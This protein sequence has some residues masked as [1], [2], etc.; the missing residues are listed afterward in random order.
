MRYYWFA[1]EPR[2]NGN[3]LWERD[4]SL[5]GSTAMMLWRP[6]GID[7]VFILNGRGTTTHKEIRTELES[8][9]EKIK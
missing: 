2:D 1:G 7:L 4:G 6:D 5:P 8:A 9:L 3:P